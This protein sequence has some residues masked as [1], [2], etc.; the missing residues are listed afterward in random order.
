MRKKERGNCKAV[1][2]AIMVTGITCLSGLGRVSAWAEAPEEAVLSSEDLSSIHSQLQEKQGT[3]WKA[4]DGDDVCIAQTISLSG[5]RTAEIQL[6]YN[7]KDAGTDKEVAVTSGVVKQ[8]GQTDLPI[9]SGDLGNL[10]QH[11]YRGTIEPETLG[12]GDCTGTVG[13]VR[14]PDGEYQVSDTSSVQLPLANHDLAR[15]EGITPTLGAVAW[16]GTLDSEHIRHGTVPICL[17]D[18]EGRTASNYQLLREVSLP[19]VCQEAPEP[20][21]GNHEDLGTS[22]MDA[23]GAD[24]DKTNS[25]GTAPGRAGEEGGNSQGSVPG[26]TPAANTQPSAVPKVSGDTGQAGMGQAGTFPPGTAAPGGV[27]GTALP[28]EG[29]FPGMGAVSGAAVRSPGGL[30]ASGTSVGS[31]DS[32]AAGGAFV[33]SPAAFK[34][35]KVTVFRTLFG[36]E[37]LRE[38]YKDGA[39]NKAVLLYKTLKPN[40]GKKAARLQLVKV[41]AAAGTVTLSAIVKTKQKAY[42]VT[43]V[44]KQAFR[45]LKKDTVIRVKA[46]TKARYRKYLRRIRKANVP[47]GVRVRRVNCI[48]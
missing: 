13:Y 8:E 46:R 32:L 26:G 29:R 4:Y 2:T 10:R 41:R 47:K 14:M 15:Q 3:F 30:E 38:V 27:S 48:K 37:W 34:K 24:A 28:D 19:A 42:R 36:T 21:S 31:P 45:K 23:E 33:K 44:G 7:S 35:R 17:V 11:S 6:K 1:F 20:D 43:K 16:D 25:M 39:G 9:S 12:L 5:G 18:A 40:K 22:G